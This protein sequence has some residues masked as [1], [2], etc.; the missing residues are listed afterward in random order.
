[1]PLSRRGVTVVE[2]LVALVLFGV[3]ATAVAGVMRRFLSG[4]RATVQSIDRRQN[5]RIAAAFLPA[6]LRALDAAD[7]DIVAMSRTAL[8]IRAPRVFGVLCRDQ[9]AGTTG[10]ATLVLSDALRY[11]VR[12]VDAD[13]DTLLILA[14]GG[15][16]RWI[17]SAVSSVGIA[18][19]ADG[20]PGIRL[21]V[22]LPA[23]EGFPA[24]TP[25]QGFET[26]TYRLYRS[27][28]DGRWYIGQQEGG[29]L[30]PLLGPV[31]ADGLALDYLDST[32]A[33]TTNPTLVRLIDVRVR[34]P[35]AEPI[36]DASGRLG[37]VIDS[38]VTLVA[39]RN[40]RRR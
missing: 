3:C 11:G 19:C 38:L 4:Y 40:N 36:R 34:A 13:S 22:T 20:R 10:A 5:L 28:E 29:S 24:G 21:G 18:P 35:T 8:T 33:V 12:D 31:T 26:I 25:V 27:S 23:P 9:P 2:L 39:L 7:G 37:Q 6:E 14:T 32:A 16:D 17:P 15:D 1:M 30:Q